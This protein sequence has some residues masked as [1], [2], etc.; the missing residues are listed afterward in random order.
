MLLLTLRGTPFV[1]QGEELG[2]EDAVITD[3]QRIDPGGRDPCRAPLPWT[4]AVGHGWGTAT[5]TWLPFPPDAAVRN[6]DAQR[7]DPGSITNLYRRL[8]AA[9]RGSPALQLGTFAW[10]RSSEGVLAWERVAGEDRRMVAINFTEQDAGLATSGTIEVASNG[11]GEGVA[12][13]G[14][15]APWQAVVL[16]P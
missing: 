10:L 1:Y 16:R 14:S 12:W 15:L 3:E 5:A 13:S 11:V 8:L 6:A 9:R 4:A 2:L 7:A